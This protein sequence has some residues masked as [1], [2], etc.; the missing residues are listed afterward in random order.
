M[1]KAL[2]QIVRISIGSLLDNGRLKPNESSHDLLRAV[3]RAVSR[4]GLRGKLRP[5]SCTH[6]A[7][8]MARARHQIYLQP[9]C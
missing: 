8:G 3:S 2:G 7:L 9:A 4:A 6:S 1:L 5:A